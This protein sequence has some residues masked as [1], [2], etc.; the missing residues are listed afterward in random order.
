MHGYDTYDY[1]AR[2]YYPAGDILPTMDPLAE[3]HP[4]TSPYVYCG[5]NPL[6][7][8]D[9]TG[10]IWGDPN[11]AEELKDKLDQKIEHLN[12][13]TTN[14]QTQVDNG[15]LS[16]DQVKDLNKKITTLETRVFQMD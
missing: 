5:N 2:G 6:N 15:D 10:M 12:Q 16:E 8:V 9:P 1:G 4:E 14:Y 11:V 7:R 13:I 3:K